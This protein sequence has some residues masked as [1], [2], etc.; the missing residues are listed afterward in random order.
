M[1][2]KMVDVNDVYPFLKL[3]Y[4]HLE[5]LRPELYNLLAETERRE[6]LATDPQE[7]S[8]LNDLIKILREKIKSQQEEERGLDRKV[9]DLV[10]PTGRRPDVIKY[11]TEAYT[12]LRGLESEWLVASDP[13]DHARLDKR[14]NEVRQ[15]IAKSEKE[16]YELD[17]EIFKTVWGDRSEDM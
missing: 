1:A 16:L 11:L 6:L 10:Y 12:I 17:L 8:K 7:D 4:D 2:K 9:Q 3:R 5:E 14:I 15:S 13:R